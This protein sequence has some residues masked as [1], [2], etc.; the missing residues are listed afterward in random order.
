MPFVFAT[1]FPYRGFPTNV[2]VA[3][4]DHSLVTLD[5]SLVCK[6]GGFVS[7]RHN[8]L[9]NTVAEFLSQVCKDVILEPELIPVTGAQ[10][11]PGTNT[12]DEAR[13]DISCRGFYS[14]LDKSLFDIRVLHPNALSNKSKPLQT[15]YATHEKEKKTK[16]LHRIL[17][18]EK[19]NFTP[20]VMATIYW[21]NV[22]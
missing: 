10:L 18:I 11:P 20:L 22:T 8:T 12:Q 7:L 17:E 15:M 13:L 9:R 21:R 5:H 14:T 2:P 1:T 6:R 19:A 4:L 16:Y 3:F